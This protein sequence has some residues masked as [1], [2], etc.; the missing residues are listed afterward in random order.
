KHGIDI[1]IG[2][3][4]ERMHGRFTGKITRMTIGNKSELFH[5]LMKTHGFT[6]KGS[7]A[8][9]DSEGDIELLSAVEKPT[10]FNPSEGLFEKAK[11]EGWPIVIERKNIAYRLE[12][13][14]DALVLAETVV[15]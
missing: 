11:E 1:A 2:A 14:D 15:F 3:E 9:G 4:Y 12:R 13:K 7:V 6:H 10:A 8:V 5:E